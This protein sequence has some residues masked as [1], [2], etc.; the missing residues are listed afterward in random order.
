MSLNVV[1]R[2]IVILLLSVLL[3]VAGF[4]FLLNAKNSS[5]ECISLSDNE[6]TDMIARIF[7]HKLERSNN[8]LILFDINPKGLKVGR[9]ERYKSEKGLSGYLEIDYL[10]TENGDKKLIAS[11]YDNCEVQW[12]KGK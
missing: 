4:Y 11:I 5:N 8:K 7:D 1:K 9:I 3:I 6:A 2:N 12:I 10:D